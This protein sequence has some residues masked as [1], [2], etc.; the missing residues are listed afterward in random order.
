[1]GIA[2]V[3]L[4]RKAWVDDYASLASGG[5]F[6][7]WHSSNGN[8]GLRCHYCYVE[9][10]GAL[11]DHLEREQFPASPGVFVDLT[12]DLVGTRLLDYQAVHLRGSFL[13]SVASNAPY[14]EGG[15]LGRCVARL[16]GPRAG[17]V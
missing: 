13:Q 2:A 9:G 6:V 17:L 1:M 16:I 15:R 12:L 4:W 8:T 5:I 3:V 11:H 14:D 10:A 7:L